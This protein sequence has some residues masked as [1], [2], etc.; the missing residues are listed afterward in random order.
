M[1]WA[2]K[3]GGHGHAVAL[4]SGSTGSSAR[5]WLH[6]LAAALVDDAGGGAHLR[7]REGGHVLLEEVHEAALALQHGQQRE[8]ARR[9]PA[10]AARRAARPAP[11]AGLRLGQCGGRWLRGQLAGR[12][13]G[14]GSAGSTAWAN[15]GLNEIRQK[16][17]DASQRRAKNESEAASVIGPG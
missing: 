12:V 15:A 3:P 1:R 7:V 4:A 9:A 2:S 14:L 11:V 5:Y 6:H 17:S 13:V 16:H 10:R 8:R